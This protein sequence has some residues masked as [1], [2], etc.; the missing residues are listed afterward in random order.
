MTRTLVL[1]GADVNLDVSQVERSTNLKFYKNRYVEE[2]DV[3]MVFECPNAPDMAE[4]DYTIQIGVCSEHDGF[5][6]DLLL[7]EA[8]DYTTE[9]TNILLE[10]YMA[11]AESAE[12]AE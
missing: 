3:V 11:A 8:A 2:E 10:Q 1:V 6:P 12:I 7:D 9:L 4:V 5:E